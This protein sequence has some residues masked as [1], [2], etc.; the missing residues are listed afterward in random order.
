MTSPPHNEQDG[1]LAGGTWLVN[2]VAFSTGSGPSL[3]SSPADNPPSAAGATGGDTGALSGGTSGSELSSGGDSLSA[4]LS[5]DVDTDPADKLAGHLGDLLK[6]GLSPDELLSA[7]MAGASAAGTGGG[8]V[9]PAALGILSS[10]YV[11]YLGAWLALMMG[12]ACSTLFWALLPAQ[13]LLMEA[14]VELTTGSVG[15]V[16]RAGLLALPSLALALRLPWLRTLVIVLR[17]DAAG[18]WRRWRGGSSGSGGSPSLLAT[19]AAA[20]APAAVPPA[21][22]MEEGGSA[23]SGVEGE[24]A[25]ASSSPQASS[26]SAAAAGEPPGLAVSVLRVAAMLGVC[27]AAGVTDASM[28][29]PWPLRAADLALSAALSASG[30][31]L[32]REVWSRGGGTFLMDSARQPLRL[33]TRLLVAQAAVGIAFAV[34]ADSWRVALLPLCAGLAAAQ[35]CLPD[36]PGREIKETVAQPDADSELPNIWLPGLVERFAGYL[37]PTYV[38]C[39][40]RLV[41]KATAEQFRGR[42]EYPSTVRLSQPVPPHAFAA[43]W[44]PPGTMRDLTLTQRQRLLRLTAASGVVANLEVAL[45]AVGFIP[46]S[47]LE[48]EILGAAAAGGLAAA[49]RCILGFGYG[50]THVIGKTLCTAAGAGHQAVC[51]VLLADDRAPGVTSQHVAA[52]LSGGHPEL[53]D[54][55]LQRWQEGPISPAD[56]LTPLGEAGNTAALQLLLQRGLRLQAHDLAATFLTGSGAVWMEALKKLR[57]YGC[58]VDGA[59]AARAGEGEGNLSVLVE[60][61]EEL[62]ASDRDPWLLEVAQDRCDLEVLRWLRQRGCPIDGAEVALSAARLG[63]LAV[64]VWAAEELGASMQSAALMDAAAASGCV[65]VMAWLRECGCPWSEGT[66]AEAARSGCVAALQWLAERGCPL[67]A[68]S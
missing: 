52:A 21:A 10:L 15:T 47:Q 14:E 2:E 19:T 56:S 64:L 33:A 11:R 63:Q 42:P 26:P 50:D 18:R 23:D 22:G 61:V 65:E 68:G 24:A 66:F 7:L 6:I 59:Q 29:A 60:A 34:V 4:E 67:Y 27:A 5:G 12:R 32:F 40:L 35:C 57:E 30:M 8:G 20:A 53:A 37:D 25:V 31:G 55:L 36:E 39:T 54:W 16:L 44:V 38:A 62:G 3:T 51:E 1:I 9:D 48:E 58:P 17:R 43:R 45:G 13:R 28:P 49:V 41:D 46:D